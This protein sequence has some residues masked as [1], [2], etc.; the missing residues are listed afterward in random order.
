M[1]LRKIGRRKD[2]IKDYIL[3]N[4]TPIEG[5]TYR[6]TTAYETYEEAMAAKDYRP[7]GIGELW[8]G[9]TNGWFRLGFRIPAEWKGRNV[10]GLFNFGGE[11][12]A[13][14]N[15]KPY[16]GLARFHQEIPLATKAGGGERFEMV[17]DVV[18]GAPWDPKAMNP[19]VTNRKSEFSRAHIATKN[20][21]VE[22]YWYNLEVL[23]LIANE[24]PQDSPRREKIIYTLNKSVDAFDYTHT[25]DESLRAS[26]LRANA[27]VKPLLE[28]PAEPSA[29]EL[30]VVGHS[31][32]DAA[33]QWPFRETKRKCARTFSTQL[34]IM[35]HY[36]EFIYSQGQALLYSFVKE[37]Y[38]SLY[39]QIKKRVKEGRWDVT[40]SMWVE[41]DCNLCSG[42]SLVR[43]ILVGKSF[44]RDE[45]GVETDVL[46]LPDV[47]GYSAALPQILKRARVNYFFTNKIHW[48]DINKP[49]YGTF[50]WKGI[51]G[52]RV[53]AHFPPSSSYNGFP[54]PEWFRKYVNNWPDKDR[55]NEILF[56]YG[57]GD[58]GGGPEARHLEY[59]RR[60]YNIE[61]LPRLKQKKVSEFF[62]GIDN[63]TDYHEWVGELYLEYHRGTYTSQAKNKRLNR[64][65]EFLMRDAEL[66]S[67]IAAPMGLPYPREELLAQWR[68]VL[69]N[70]FHDII[71][72]TS[73]RQVY[74]ETYESYDGVLA[75]GEKAV[76]DATDSLAARIDTTGK[77][78][79]IIVLNTLPWERRDVV[80]LRAPSRE[81]C[82]V[83]DAFG[84]QV[85]VQV[86]AGELR[87]TASVPSM[88]YAVY[89][90]VEKPS[91][92]V[93]ALKVSKSRLEN[94]FFRI[95]LDSKGLIESILHKETGREV[96]PMGA[97]ANV[98]EFYEDKP[99]NWPAWDID[100]FHED[101]VE[102]I[103]E[104]KS[105]SVQE[106]GPVLGAVEIERE[107]SK[108]RLRQ[109]IVIY[110][111]IP[112]I[113][114]ETWVDWHEKEK[115]LK[116][117]F[118]V[119]VNSPTARYE[120]QFGNVERPTHRNT[121]W[122]FAKF[123]VCAHK[124][125][126]LSEAD[127]GVS[128]MND[129]K[130][131]HSVKGSVMRLTLL[132]SAKK[133]DPEAD[134]GEH[135]FTYSLMPH[136][137]SYV[138]ARTVRRAYELNVPLRTV[139][140]MSHKGKLPNRKSFIS[141]DAENVVLE[142]VK[143]AEREEATILR[144][145]ECHN[146]RSH[147][148]VSIDLPFRKVYECDLMEDNTGE[149]ASHDGGF[150]FE[151]KPFEIRTFKLV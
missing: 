65:S 50:W 15:G 12:C 62:H 45:F 107:F 106:Q 130:Y 103:T 143:K 39:S 81:G 8:G 101:K 117:A 44:Y 40:G 76:A 63:G 115:L 34:A 41:A 140:P 49:P 31:H 24:L 17:A 68:Q 138:D 135:I 53:L 54:N 20:P 111:D 46:W 129:C 137:G 27:I 116:V 72:G 120:I 80:T 90:M 97:R 28:C 67:T 14:L 37:N 87:F 7:I 5:I 25:D 64:R 114:F 36:P 85:T 124:W 89:R 136:A 83:T 147:V 118:P 43:Q 3:S 23:H 134:M 127:F 94:R 57:W 91:K 146:K 35:E 125:V 11:A 22:E 141:V 126:D 92:A 70:Q 60:E 86:S 142:T 38:P 105:I 18:S 113:D 133:P 2:E 77:G 75:A 144:F 112:R 51:D 121:S 148:I 47:F 151:I 9:A 88:G 69:A 102:E 132:K 29:M 119:D 58:G 19:Q 61:G 149:V 56:T 110:S 128:L 33:W 123:E 78:N 139:F 131:G 55:A 59:L 30:A 95:D 109:R 4:V 21:E 93:S 82:A 6:E 122:D 26:A 145:Y 73:I 100:F 98:F 96:L 84:E 16:H 32:I 104:L 52:S 66:L 74:E 71:P 79:A 48:S 150:S 108:S 13:Y 1:L 99:L 10:V 42:E